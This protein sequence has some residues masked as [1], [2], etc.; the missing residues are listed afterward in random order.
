M[1]TSSD[2]RILSAEVRTHIV[3]RHRLLTQIPDLDE[4][5]LA[6][7]LGGLTNLREMM[8]AAIRST[9]D[10]EALAAALAAR[11]ADLKARLERI[12]E[13]AKI[14]R[15]LVLQA[16]VEAELPKLAEADFLAS[17]RQG[18]PVLEIVAEDEV[19]AAYWKPQ[20]PKLDKLGMLAALKSGTQID[21]AVLRAPQMQL[22]VRIK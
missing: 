12:G 17:L 20:P 21:G 7:T 14:K 9:L 18:N 15:Q 13:R 16:M 22:S 3:F 1:S 10:D 2:E 5:T 4:Q 19:P 11:I 8:A 6:D